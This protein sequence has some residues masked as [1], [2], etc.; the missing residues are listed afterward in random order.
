MSI[1]VKRYVPCQ[2]IRV[3]WRWWKRFCLDDFSRWGKIFI[4][5]RTHHNPIKW[6]RIFP[7]KLNFNER[8]GTPRKNK[9]FDKMRLPKK[10]DNRFHFSR[11]VTN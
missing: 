1:S 11:V 9:A 3:E 8:F 5:K 10:F 2:W 4:K 6:K 7:R